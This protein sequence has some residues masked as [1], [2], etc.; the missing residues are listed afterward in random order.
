MLFIIST[1]GR[2]IDSRCD[3]ATALLRRPCV[4]HPSISTMQKYFPTHE[5]LVCTGVLWLLLKLCFSPFIPRTSL[6]LPL[7]KQPTK[8]LKLKIEL[9]TDN[10]RALPRGNT[11]LSPHLLV[12]ASCLCLLLLFFLFLLVFFFFCCYLRENPAP[13]TEAEGGIVLLRTSPAS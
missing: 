4:P 5:S 11:T 7:P 12:S 10:V 2:L 13:A 1:F 9:R 6:P 8:C 3:T